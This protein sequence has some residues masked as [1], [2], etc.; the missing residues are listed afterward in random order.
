MKITV[1]TTG[2]FSLFDLHAGKHIDCGCQTEV[3]LTPFITEQLEIGQLKKV[4]RAKAAPK[5][6][7]VVD[8]GGSKPKAQRAK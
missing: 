6:D 5:A 2:S 7:P 4:E 8:K 3:E 1:E